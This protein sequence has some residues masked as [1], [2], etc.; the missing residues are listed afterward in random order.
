M[1]LVKAVIRNVIF[2]TLYFVGYDKKLRNKTTN[3]NLV[4]MFH[5]VTSQESTW[6]SP[7]HIKLDHF[8]KLIA[9]ISSN[10]NVVDAR[11]MLSSRNSSKKHKKPT[12]SLTFDDGYLNNFTLA[13]PILEKYKVPA[14]FFVSTVCQAN[15]EY[16]VLWAD[17]VT[18]IQKIGSIKKLVVRSEKFTN[19]VSEKGSFLFDALKNLPALERDQVL[20]K[21]SIE[22][23]LNELLLLVDSEIWQMMSIEQLKELAKSPYVTL[24][25]HGHMHYNLGQIELEEAIQD[26]VRSKNLL[27][28]WTNTQ[29]NSIAFPDGSYSIELSKQLLGMGLKYQFAVSYMDEN[30]K[31]F[32]QLI[33][34]F[35]VSSTTTFKS[36]V[37]HI[38][39]AF[40]THGF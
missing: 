23:N 25:S 30:H 6:F 20:E 14:T 39:K 34:R 9:Y 29:V 24:G 33:N 21:W 17:A 5:G 8:E 27:E 40:G 7:R 38:N 15:K 32:N 10:Y 16:K 2:P 35:G 3:N 4:L 13:L 31:E 12:V 26:V 19:G 1:S 28:E 36:N 37:F 11:E 18:T 22:Y